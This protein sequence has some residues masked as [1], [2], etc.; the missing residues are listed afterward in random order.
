MTRRN[1]QDRHGESWKSE[2]ATRFRC[3]KTTFWWKC[4]S[5]TEDHRFLPIGKFKKFA[6]L[7]ERLSDTDEITEWSKRSTQHVQVR[8]AILTL[9]R[10]GGCWF[11]S[12]SWLLREWL[13]WFPFSSD[14]C[15]SGSLSPNSGT[16]LRVTG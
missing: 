6:Q 15:R 9:S 7:H 4:S 14:E 3:M 16:Y 5:S 2:K 10:E 12:G 13:P 1:Q 11:D 8:T